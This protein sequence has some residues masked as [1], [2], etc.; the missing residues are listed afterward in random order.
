MPSAKKPKM[1]LYTHVFGVYYRVITELH[2]SKFSLLRHFDKQSNYLLSIKKE[3]W[4]FS[5]GILLF[6]VRRLLFLFR[7]FDLLD[8]R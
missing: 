1:P 8:F 2:F 3:P 5:Q 4:D 7:L 6:P